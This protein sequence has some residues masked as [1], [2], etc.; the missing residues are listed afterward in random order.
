MWPGPKVSFQQ[1]YE[2]ANLDVDP[3]TAVKPSAES[4]SL[5]DV[6]PSASSETLR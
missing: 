4:S 1:P 2:C 3:P 6:L 5:A